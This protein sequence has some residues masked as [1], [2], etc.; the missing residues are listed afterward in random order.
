MK[1]AKFGG[2][3]LADAGQIRKVCEIVKADPDR[4]LVV[5]SAPG[6]RHKQ[7]TKVTDL[8]IK[9]A[10]RRIGGGSTDPELAAV[11]DRYG[12]I[13]K[14]LGLP[15]ELLAE[16]ERD[17][18]HRIAV[19]GDNVSQ[20]TDAVKAAG[21]DHCARLTA[22]AMRTMGMD[23]RYICP[24]D[25]GLL[26]S[27]DFGNA[28]VLPESYRRLEALKDIRGIGVFPG[29]FG[30]TRS[31][32]VVTFPRGGSDITGSILAAAVGCGLGVRRGA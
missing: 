20:F 19:V 16:I 32:A 24:K 2:T 23:A 1:V 17:L 27:D 28:Q 18:R 15:A 29:F 6:K 4:R 30:Y 5:V 7:D 14:D 25:A 26:L 11:L 21:E 10:E 3:S 22:A 31:G 8:L 12:E 9:L 13:Q